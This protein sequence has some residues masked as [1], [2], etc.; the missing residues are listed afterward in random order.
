VERVLAGKS[1]AGFGWNDVPVYSFGASWDVNNNWTLRAGMSIGDQPVVYYENT[2][3]I[4]IFNLTEAHYTA[5]V[6]RR[7]HNG[8]EWSLALMYAEE[9]SLEAVNQLDS[10][11]I[12]Q[13]TTDQFDIQLSYS[14]KR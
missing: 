13:M 14:W 1:G 3:N 9:D 10:S 7:L 6:S 4:P 12:V 11:Q 8:D 2:F 5:G